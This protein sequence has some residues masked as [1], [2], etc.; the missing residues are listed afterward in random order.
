[1]RSVGRVSCLRHESGSLRWQRERTE[2]QHSLISVCVRVGSKERSSNGMNWPHKLAKAIPSRQRP[3]VAPLVV[4]PSF[5]SVTSKLH[6][7]AVLL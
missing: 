7:Q 3:H 6:A 4:A 1:M 2:L 5:S